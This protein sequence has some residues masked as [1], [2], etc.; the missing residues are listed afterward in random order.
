M[1]VYLRLSILEDGIMLKR[2]LNLRVTSPISVSEFYDALRTA[3]QPR[4]PWAGLNKQ[5]LGMTS[6][7]RTKSITNRWIGLAISGGVDSMALAVLCQKLQLNNSLTKP[8]DF[9]F[10]PFIVDHKARDGS[11]EEVEKVASLVSSLLG[12]MTRRWR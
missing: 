11:S 4:G 12:T 8:F 3:W 6:K 2:K 10:V 7:R 9:T 1:L 5:R